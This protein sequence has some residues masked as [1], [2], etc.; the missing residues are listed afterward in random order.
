MKS[1]DQNFCT[2]LVSGMPILVSGAVQ[3]LVSVKV[4]A[5]IIEYVLNNSSIR[6]K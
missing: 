6:E 2:V 4:T 5:V 3:A 1:V